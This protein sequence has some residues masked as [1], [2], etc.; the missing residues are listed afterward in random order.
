[1]AVDIDPKDY[2]NSFAYIAD[3]WGYSLLGYSFAQN[4]ASLLKHRFLLANPRV[5]FEGVSGL[6][7]SPIG[8][9]GYRTLYFHPI[10]SFE[11]FAVSTVVF[12][13]PETI[14]NPTVQ[15]EVCNN[16]T[17]GCSNFSENVNIS[18]YLDNRI[19]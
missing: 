10:D 13:N 18:Y 1:M 17:I 8:P 3:T 16:L 4:K 6:A 12:R 5:G 7:L 2:N 19:S 11:E 15:F 9:D 14:R